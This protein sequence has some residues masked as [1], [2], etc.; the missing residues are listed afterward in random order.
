MRTRLPDL[1]LLVLVALWVL[2]VQNDPFF[3]DTVQ[4]GSKHAH[5]FYY[6]QLRWTALP[7]NIDS[8]HPPA[9][10]YYLAIVW[11]IFGKTLSASHWAMFPFLA[12]IALLSRRIGMLLN[13][14]LPWY[15]LTILIALDPVVAGQ[16][17]LIGPDIPLAFFFLL[18]LYGI[19][20][21][22]PV[23]ILAGITGLCMISM[24]GMMTAAALLVWQFW[25][26]WAGKPAI[27]ERIALAGPF[28]PG[29]LLAAVF[30]AW[31][32]YQTGWT[33]FHPGSP[34]APAFEKVKGLAFLKNIAVLIWRMLDFGRFAEWLALGVLLLFSGRKH[35]WGPDRHPVLFDL[36]AL[37]VTTLVLLSPSALLYQNLSAHRY[38]LP[39]F[40]ALHLFFFNWLNMTPPTKRHKWLWAS[41]VALCLGT[42]NL[43]IYPQG[44]SMGWDATLAHRPYHTLRAEMLQYIDK[45]GLELNS[46]GTA[47][48]NINTGEALLLN[49]DYRI[50]AQMDLQ[51]NAYLL[52]S[53]VFNDISPEDFQH[54]E[55]E[56]QVEYQ[57]KRAGVTMTL[58]RKK[59]SLL[60]N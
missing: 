31:H 32:Q 21:N 52:T 8:G 7:E 18:A 49:G 53:N 13:G 59:P 46:I 50:F 38:F 37:L 22:K 40:L 36:F 12:G 30:L 43:W 2:F 27:R 4:L 35:L 42:G 6:R 23:L 56:W 20:R 26:S 15:T 39:T 19:F 1:I 55:R 3:W 41:A 9:F 44:I 5:F 17:A 58:Y 34:W 28:L 45:N 47:F 25:R 14:S 60:S 51:Q 16:A 11:T 10:G 54:L 57:L 29:F 33:G 48:P 24:R